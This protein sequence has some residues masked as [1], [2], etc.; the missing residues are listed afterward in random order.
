VRDD[1]SIDRTR[2]PGKIDKTIAPPAGTTYIGAPGGQEYS[3]FLRADGVVDR[4]AEMTMFKKATGEISS[5]YEP[6]EGAKYIGISEMFA[7]TPNQYDSSP[8]SVY[9]VRD[10]GAVDRVVEQTLRGDSSKVSA[11]LN[12]P[13]GKLYVQASSGMHNSYLV[14]SDGKVARTAGGGVVDNELLSP[15]A[16]G[17]ALDGGDAG[18]GGGGGC[19]VM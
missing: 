10:D 17:A 11:T 18:E 3:Y 1:G 5:S 6:P 15:P 2:G 12:P 13:P 7:V 16:A 19:A 14:Q 8:P 4:T 9:L